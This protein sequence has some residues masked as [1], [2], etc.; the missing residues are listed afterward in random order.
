[1]IVQNHDSQYNNTQNSE[2]PLH[3]RIKTPETIKVTIATLGRIIL[4]I[5]THIIMM[6]L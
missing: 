6:L 5:I 3:A 4:R 1:M 2:A